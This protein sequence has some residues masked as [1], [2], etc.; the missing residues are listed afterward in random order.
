MRYKFLLTNHSSTNT[1][2]EVLNTHYIVFHK[3]VDETYLELRVKALL[4]ANGVQLPVKANVTMLGKTQSI[5][6]K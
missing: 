3:T 5:L 1:E 6:I 4:L 2:V